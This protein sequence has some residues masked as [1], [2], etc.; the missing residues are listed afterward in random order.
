MVWK[1]LTCQEIKEE[2]WVVLGGCIEWRG[3][4]HS[5][6][7]RAYPHVGRERIVSQGKY[8][9]LLHCH[10]KFTKEINEI[11]VDKLASVWHGK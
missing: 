6:W 7:G 8:E 2:P 9:L 1:L 3:G 10:E 4:A 5:T 11:T